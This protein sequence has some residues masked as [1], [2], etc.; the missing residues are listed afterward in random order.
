M[1][2]NDVIAHLD[3]DQGEGL[4]GYITAEDVKASLYDLYN[5]IITT[6]SEGPIG[7]QGI[8]G[9]LGPQGIAGPVGPTGPA[10]TFDVGTVE[11]GTADAS[12]SGNEST[13]YH[14]NLVLPSAGA[15]GVNTAAIQNGAVTSEKIANGTITN[16]DV[17][18]AADIDRSKIAGT[19]L[20]AES[21]SI[22]NVKDYGALGDNSHDDTAAI[23][24][25]ID[26]AGGCEVY[27]PSGDY[28][29]AGALTVPA[30]TRLRGGVAEWG[31][32]TAFTTRLRF[33]T[34][35]NGFVAVTLGD[36]AEIV[37]LSLVGTFKQHTNYAE[38]TTG[39]AGGN[40]VLSGLSVSGFY[41][42]VKMT[43]AY[44]SHLE[45]VEFLRNRVGL[46]LS[47]CYNVNLYN[48]HFNDEPTFGYGS[49]YSIIAGTCHSLTIH[50][51]ALEGYENGI[52][53]TAGGLSLFGVYFETAVSSSYG[54]VLGSG[55][56]LTMVGC[57][58]YVDHNFAFVYT[59]QTNVVI[60]AHGNFFCS[61][62]TNDKTCVV[63]HIVYAKDATNQ[64]RLRGDNWVYVQDPGITYTG[65]FLGSGPVANA[66]IEE[67]A[68]HTTGVWGANGPKYAF[69]G[70]SQYYPDGANLMFGQTTGSKIGLATDKIGF[71]GASPIAKPTGVAVSA[72]G[73]HAALVSLGLIAGP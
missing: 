55:S 25:C 70:R 37:N 11:T 50:G 9:P 17:N 69:V 2:I 49:G 15:D 4:E 58:A 59:T 65:T 35:T 51:G 1:A 73:V 41:Y 72:A 54:I 12:L 46:N 63:Y 38:T 67:P 60:D 71:F 3:P 36:Y 26:A 21:M 45:R 32:P 57:I 40:C 47:G 53:I 68:N 62:A 43:A 16:G 20:T 44:Y 61:Q 56:S 39:V 19:A 23:Q 5:L 66:H 52:D 28:L 34:H 10:P 13:G 64:I 22:F 42:G 48:C 24:A 29:C 27:F 6:V 8:Q 33:S 14:L 30:N 31:N 7:P 18:A